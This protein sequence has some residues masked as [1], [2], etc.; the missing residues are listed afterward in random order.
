MLAY[1]VLSDRSSVSHKDFPGPFSVLGPDA[2]ATA[3]GNGRHLIHAE[4]PTP[5]GIG[6]ALRVCEGTEPGSRTLS[7]ED[8]KITVGFL[9]EGHDHSRFIREDAP[10]IYYNIEV[11]EGTGMH[12]P[13]L[14]RID[15]GPTLPNRVML[16]P[17]GRL[18]RT[19]Q[20]KY[21]DVVARAERL[22]R[23]FALLRGFGALAG[24]EASKDEDAAH[25]IKV[26]QE[27]EVSQEDQLKLLYD[28]IMLV[29]RYTMAELSLME[30][31]EEDG[32]IELLWEMIDGDGMREAYEA[33]Q[34]KKSA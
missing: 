34:K 22:F 6:R 30:L 26:C 13:M 1:L 2:G 19:M 25:Y 11:L 10:R 15:G 32:V 14:Y 31:F 9:A 7:I 5:E 23:M 8:G 21:E 33:L 27:N 16:G 28:A 3:L 12:V 17:D 4:Q 24:I 18:R 20:P 29:H